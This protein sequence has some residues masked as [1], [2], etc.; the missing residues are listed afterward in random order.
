MKLNI[1]EKGHAKLITVLSCRKR[2]RIERLSLFAFCGF[3]RCYI[4][5]ANLGLGGPRGVCV[6]EWGRDHVT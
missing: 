5:A 2:L 3:L 1:L 6:V 4:N